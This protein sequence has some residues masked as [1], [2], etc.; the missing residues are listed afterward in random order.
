MKYKLLI[1]NERH[2]WPYGT[3]WEE[4][5]IDLEKRAPSIWSQVESNLATR[6]GAAHA[7]AIKLLQELHEMAKHRGILVETKKRILK[8]YG[9][10]LKRDALVRRFNEAG[11]I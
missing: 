9:E 7:E 10:N 2:G 5:Y 1:E 6:S 8:I 4:Y 11:L 3:T